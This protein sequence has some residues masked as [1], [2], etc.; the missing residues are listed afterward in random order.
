MNTP[1]HIHIA[2]KGVDWQSGAAA[3]FW[4]PLRKTVAFASNY[5]D[6]FAAGDMSVEKN[7]QLDP[8]WLEYAMIPVDNDEFVVHAIFNPKA[9]RCSYPAPLNHWMTKSIAAIKSGDTERAAKFAGCIS[10]IIG[11]TGQAA[12]VFEDQLLK[13]LMPQ[14]DKCF[15]IHSTI[16]K[17]CGKIADAEYA[18][19][20]L[21]ATMAELCWRLIE[22]LEMLKRRETGEVIPI[23]QAILPEDNAAAEASATR[24]AGHCAELFADLLFSLWAI[25]SGKTDGAVDEFDLRRLIPVNQYCD[26][27]FNYEIMLDHIPGREINR[28]LPLNPGTESD[29]PGICLLANMAPHFRNVREAF[30]EYSIPGGVFKYFTALIGLNH[31]ALNQTSAVFKVELDGKTIFESD[32]L[33]AETPLAKVK[34]ELGN[35]KLLRLSARDSRRAPCDTK[36]FYPVFAI[37]RLTK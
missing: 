6:Y 27:L 23:M 20:L 30:V 19:R 25:A 37:P 4:R 9:I 11:D 15:V 34:I 26:M 17:V 32:A 33:D 13:Q 31:H 12:H 7:I 14:G 21:G 22:E 35:A 1:M 16:E 2:E 10:H 5:P 28:P 3:A 36:F 29:L 8:D 24:T 18:P